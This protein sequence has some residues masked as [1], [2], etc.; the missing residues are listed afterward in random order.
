MPPVRDRS[1]ALSEASSGLSG[2]IVDS[3]TNIQSVKLFAHAEREDAF[4]LRGFRR[5]I[6]AFPR[7]R[8]A[9]GDADRH[10]CRRINSALIVADRRPLRLAVD[11]GPRSRVGA[12]AL[13]TS[14]VLRLNQMSTMI[15]RQITS[16]F[17]NVGAVAER[18]ADD[19]PAACA[20]RLRRTRR[21]C[22]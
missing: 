11:A 8:R 15:L 10:R 1:A 3:Y 12:I 6:E 9:H 21:R 18:R 17:E 14:L 7:L 4:A 16:L 22:G 2:R 19:Q 5:H 13:A 20:G